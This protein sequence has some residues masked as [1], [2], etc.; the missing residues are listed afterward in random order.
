MDSK[1]DLD[2]F[3]DTPVRYLGYANEIGESFRSMIS[4]VAVRA[5]YGVSFGYVFMDVI[6]KGK[7]TFVKEKKLSESG[8]E[9]ESPVIK[10]AKIATDCLV[11]QSFASVIIPGFTINRIC[12][13]S[14]F[15]L[16][17]NGAALRTNKILSTIIGLGSIPLI[18]HPIDHACHKVMDKTIRPMIGLETH[19]K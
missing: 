17:K 12:K 15:I 4:Q 8:V 1:P 18:I 5:T 7:K 19:I 2:I 6:D 10:T 13:L 9:K 16:Q 14:S 3:R 11:W